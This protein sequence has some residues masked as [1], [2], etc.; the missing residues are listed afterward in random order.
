MAI[1]KY[2][3]NLTWV[4]VGEAGLQDL[5]FQTPWFSPQALEFSSIT[6]EGWSGEGGKPGIREDRCHYNV[7]R[8]LPVLEL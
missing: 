7:V 3:K 1:K 2:L 5:K 6:M 4:G 8:L